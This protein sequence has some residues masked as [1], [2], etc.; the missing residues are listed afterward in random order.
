MFFQGLTPTPLNPTPLNPYT[1]TH[2]DT[3]AGKGE[4]GAA[5]H[6]KREF[7]YAVEELGIENML[8]VVTELCCLDLKTW[9][10]CVK[11]NLGSTLYMDVTAVYVYV[12][13]HAHTHTHTHTHTR[14]DNMYIRL[15]E[16]VCVCVYIF[17]YMC[18][19]VHTCI[20]VCERERERVLNIYTHTHYICMRESVCLYYINMYIYIHMYNTHSLSRTHTNIPVH[21]I[22]I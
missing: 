14:R 5:D 17:T 20:F 21:M 6:C 19:H 8:A 22:Y 11:F 13:T 7:E 1:Y 16:Y 3:C 9:H 2:I 18:V 10:G 4:R 12:C 15:N